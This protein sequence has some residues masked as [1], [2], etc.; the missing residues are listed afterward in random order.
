[1]AIT[2]RLIGPQ[3]EKFRVIVFMYSAKNDNSTDIFVMLMIAVNGDEKVDLQTVY[4]TRKPP[5]L[6]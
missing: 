5:H 3:S 1:M 4:F 6:S 2:W